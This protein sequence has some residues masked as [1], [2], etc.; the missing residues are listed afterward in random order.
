[1]YNE[2]ATRK[3]IAYFVCFMLGIIMI[4]V[5]TLKI[6]KTSASPDEIYCYPVE[7]VRYYETKGTLLISSKQKVEV[8]YKTASET[9]KQSFSVSNIEIGEKTEIAINI[10][11]DTQESYW[12]ESILYM[13]KEDYA[14][15]LPEAVKE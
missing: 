5:V 4:L 12:Q 10:Y 8:I 15:L 7:Y 1:M 9:I 13:T 14:S 6:K 11:G 3:R 2:I